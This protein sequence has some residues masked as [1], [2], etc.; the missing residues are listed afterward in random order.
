MQK[1]AL[2]FHHAGSRE[3]SQDDEAWH[4]APLPTEN[5]SRL[6]IIYSSIWFFIFTVFNLASNNQT[7][8]CGFIWVYKASIETGGW[9]ELI[10]EKLC[11]KEARQK[12]MG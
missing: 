4:Q 2:F 1:V 11:L 12:M 8:G 9:L 6:S 10:G 5:L 7:I 3:L